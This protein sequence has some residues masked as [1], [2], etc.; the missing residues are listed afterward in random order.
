MGLPL[1]QCDEV[2]AI[3][4]NE[5]VSP[6]VREPKHRL[7]CSLWAEHVADAQHLVLEFAKQVRQILRNVVVEKERHDGS[8]AGAICRATSKSISPR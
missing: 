6:V 8:A 1:S 4:G 3:A 5:Q 2:I 7:V